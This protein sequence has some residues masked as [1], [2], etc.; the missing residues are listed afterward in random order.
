ML[1]KDNKIDTDTATTLLKSYNTCLKIDPQS[2][3]IWHYLAVFHYS[4]IQNYE[5]NKNSTL[6]VDILDH[7]LKA[8]ESFYQ[9]LTISKTK[10]QDHHI[11]QDVLRIIT[12]WFNFGSS[13]GVKNLLISG[14]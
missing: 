3:I 2:Y 14:I 11:V 6:G 7:I 5:P 8:L 12:I 13:K 1:I 10:I 9:T 4:Y